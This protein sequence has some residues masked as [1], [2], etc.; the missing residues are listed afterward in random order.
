MLLLYRGGHTMPGTSHRWWL[1][2]ILALGLGPVALGQSADDL[3]RSAGPLLPKSS[4]ATFKSG[5]QTIK[6]WKYV[7]AEGN[8][9]FPGIVLLNG[10][11]G[12]DLLQTDLKVQLL[13][14]TLASRMAQQGYVVHF[15]HY[16]NRT[17]F[18]KDEIPTVK[19]AFL[20]QTQNGHGSGP[21]APELEPKLEQHYR[22]WM[23][24]VRDAVNDLRQDKTLVDGDRIGIVGLSMGGFVGTSCVVEYPEL[25]IAALAN[26]FGGMPPQQQAQVRKE[27]TKLPPIL[28]MGGEEDDIVPE[29]YQREL[30]QLWRDTG[31]RA[32]AHFYSGY[33]HAF[34]DKR[35]KTFDQNMALNEALPTAQRFLKR[36]LQ[37]K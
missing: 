31:N 4:D 5:D 36:Y 16:M 15:V 22:E 19:D 35:L 26:I 2:A 7:P 23:E 24:T 25:K 12:L 10:I 37:A 18:K 32:E 3:K 28:I 14:R 13:Y 1:G 30:F 11:D 20:R 21:K 17:P 9:P 27:K 6:V 29:V 34:F 8:A 33:G